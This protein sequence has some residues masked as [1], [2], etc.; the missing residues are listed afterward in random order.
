MVAQL[1][2]DLETRMQKAVEAFRREIASLKAGRA[3]PALLD[4]VMVDYYGTPT[5]V[6]QL[7]NLTAPEPRLIV[8]QPWDKSAVP[9]I[10]K[11]I[12]KSDLGLTPTS[13]GTVIRLALP[14]LTE[15]RRKE[16]V[17]GLQRQTEEQRVAVRNVRRDGLDQLKKLRKEGLPEDEERQAEADIQKLTD[18]YIAEIDQISAAKEKDI[19][20]V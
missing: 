3:T 13:D 14:Q 4:R 10:E 18:K 1:F 12:L 7:A 16:L 2:S 8:I 11:A 20:E 19:L 15:E 9:L 5:P 17:R 6:N